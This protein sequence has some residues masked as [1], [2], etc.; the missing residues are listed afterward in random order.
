MTKNA[1]ASLMK[2]LALSAVAI[3]IVVLAAVMAN[4]EYQQS[5][6]LLESAKVFFLVGMLLSVLVLAPF[7]IWRN[8]RIDEKRKRDIRRTSRS[9]TSHSSGFI[10]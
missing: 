3:V 8:Q 9:W 1:T 10:C 5:R 6:S 7:G 2:W 4:R